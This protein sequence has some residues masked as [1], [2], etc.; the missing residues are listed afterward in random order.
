MRIGSRGKNPTKSNHTVKHHGDDASPLAPY[1]QPH[2]GLLRL[3]LAG[4]RLMDTTS[5]GL[6]P[7]PPPPPPPE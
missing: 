1:P 4:Q 5:H 2:L 7:P 6:P 3:P